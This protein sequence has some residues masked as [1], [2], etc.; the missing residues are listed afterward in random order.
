MS[1]ETIPSHLLLFDGVC[2]LCNASVNFVIRNDKRQRFYFAS[3]QSD[4][5]RETL[6]VKAPSIKD[7]RTV[8]YIEKGKVYTESTAVLRM[9]RKLRFPLNLLYAFIIIPRFIRDPLYR[10]IAKNRYRWFGKK[11]ACMIPSPELQHRFL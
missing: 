10:Y 9:L 2:N 1:A 8:V 11:D 5:A 4:F 7:M 6:S 3:L